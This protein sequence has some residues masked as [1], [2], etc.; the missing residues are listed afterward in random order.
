MEPFAHQLDVGGRQDATLRIL[1]PADWR[2]EQELSRVDDVPTWTMYPP[3][4]TEER[5]RARAA[6]NVDIAEAGLGI[7]YLVIDAGEIV[8]TAGFG[9]RADGEY[10]IFYA[11]KPVGR[12]RGLATDAVR[13]L[14]GW[15]DAQ[16]EHSSWLSTLDGNTA[17][18]NVAKRTG[19]VPVGSGVHVDA[20]PITVW[21][22]DA[23]KSAPA[24]AAPPLG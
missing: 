3:D 5:A 19:F 2:I 24:V 20:R 9:R 4:L 12:G 15:L 1:T 21:R 23:P 7:R 6:L 17:S 11:L 18:E 16:G 14:V 8:G 13:T 22:R 10:E